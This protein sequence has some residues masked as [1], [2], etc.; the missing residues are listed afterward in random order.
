LHLTFKASLSV[1]GLDLAEELQGLINA[2]GLSGGATSRHRG[3][4]GFEHG[5]TFA[6]GLELYWTD[7]DGEGPNPGYSSLQLKGD[8]FRQLGPEEATLAF[9]LLNDL[10]PYRCT[11]IDAQMTHCTEP[12]VPEIIRAFRSSR[13]RTKQKKTFEPKGREAAGGV[14]P[15]GATIVHGSR[16]S[17]NYA[18]QYDKHLEQLAQGAEDPGPPRRRDEIELKGATALAVWKE[19]VVVLNQQLEQD[20]PNWMAEAAFCKGLIRHY[21]PIRDVSQWEGKELPTN[22]AGTAP[23]PAW[24]A[25]HFSE[26]AIRARRERGPSSTLLKRIGYMNRTYGSLY[27][28]EFVLEMLKAEER[29]DDLKVASSYAQCVI[30]DRLFANAQDHRLEELLENLPVAKHDR[31]RELWWSAVRAAADGEE[32]DRDQAESEK[33]RM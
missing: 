5:I 15:E 3:V 31:A 9:L 28:Q 12:L 13:L 19:L 17:E 10:R 6:A 4:H 7:G 20:R 33:P 1:G 32:A 24:W 30:R 27:T 29:Y 2:L 16:Q 26:E 23:E 14:Y 25:K 22:W 8:F 18:R 21:L 11:R